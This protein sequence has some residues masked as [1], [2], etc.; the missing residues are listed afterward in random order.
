MD[1]ALGSCVVI[2]DSFSGIEGVAVAGMT[3]A[4]MTVLGFAGGGHIGAGHDGRMCGAGGHH[5]LG[6]MA[7]LPKLL[8][9]L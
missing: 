7:A 8:S 1:V 3:V 9:R 2:K 5:V 6:D 4:G